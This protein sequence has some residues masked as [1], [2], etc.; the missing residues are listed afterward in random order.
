MPYLPKYI[1][2]RIKGLGK[3]HPPRGLDRISD[4]GPIFSGPRVSLDVFLVSCTI[5]S[6]AAARLKF[7]DHELPPS[8]QRASIMRNVKLRIRFQ[9][10]AVIAFLAVTILLS[11]TAIAQQEKILFSFPSFDV[12]YPRAGL[13]VGH[14]IYGTASQDGAYDMG[15]SVFALVPQSGG[16]TDKVLH[17]FSGNGKGGYAPFAGLVMDKS[18]NLYGT[19]L[20]GGNL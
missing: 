17:N 8:R 4:R 10:K 7:P 18:G 12:S 6:R 19:T 9:L 5:F 14:T 2:R 16:W 13:I 3:F 20:F 11:A 1:L 15:G